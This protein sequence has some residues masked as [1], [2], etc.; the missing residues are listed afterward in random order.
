MASW[1]TWQ[2]KQVVLKVNSR[3]VQGRAGVGAVGEVPHAA[4]RR[5]VPGLFVHIVGHWQDLQAPL[6]HL[7]EEI[8]GVLA[9]HDVGDGIR[10]LSGSTRL[11]H[12][13]G[14][15]AQSARNAR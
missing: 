9:A 15:R 4:G 1:L 14:A 11:T 13:P 7:R 2:S 8:V 6:G 10:L 5:V 3:S 12:D